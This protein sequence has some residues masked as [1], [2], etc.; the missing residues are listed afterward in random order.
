VSTVLIADDHPIFRRGLRAVI[1]AD[2]LLEVTAEASGGREAL[3]LLRGR[4][5]H[6][7]VLDIEMPDLDGLEVLAQ[8]RTWPDPPAV[9]MLTMHDEY[10]ERAFGLGALGYLLKENAADEVVTC[11]HAVARGERFISAGLGWRARPDGGV[12]RLGA[13]A[14]LSPSE[15]RVLKLLAELRSAA[16][17]AKILSISPRTVQNHCAHMCTKLELRGP[18][19]LLKFALEHQAELAK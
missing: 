9:V 11:L 5:A 8:S 2:P 12:E 7:A 14:A 4:K 6:L 17:I 19:A 13:L 15:R 16:E 1:E 3:E 18:K 10:L